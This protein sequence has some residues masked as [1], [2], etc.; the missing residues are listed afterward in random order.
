MSSCWVLSG[1]RRSVLWLLWATL[2]VP[3]SGLGPHPTSP[4]SRKALGTRV[5]NAEVDG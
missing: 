5:V 3:A 2:W 1:G 4:V